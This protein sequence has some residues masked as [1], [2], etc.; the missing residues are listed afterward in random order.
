MLGLTGLSWEVLTW[1]LFCGCSQM[2]SSEGSTGLGTQGSLILGFPLPFPAAKADSLY[3]S[4]RFREAGGEAARLVKELLLHHFLQALL[5]MW[6][7]Q[8][9]G[10]PLPYPPPHDGSAKP[11]WP[12]SICP[13]C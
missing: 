4:S 13:R 5:A 10:S 12:C 6:P 7:S 3:Q 8:K 1:G 2:G 9:E 11:L